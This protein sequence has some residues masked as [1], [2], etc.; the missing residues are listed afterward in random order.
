MDYINYFT[1][2]KAPG[3]DKLSHF[4]NEFPFITPTT[5][6]RLMQ[7]FDTKTT[8]YKHGKVDTG[9][10]TEAVDVANVVKSFLNYSKIAIDKSFILAIKSIIATGKYDHETMKKKLEFQSRSLVK[11]VNSKQY[12]ELLEEIYNFKSR[13]YVSFKEKARSNG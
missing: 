9:N 2:E 7:K 4:L 11:C 6:I 8:D 1:L 12:I 13:D 5:A 10:Y 3:F